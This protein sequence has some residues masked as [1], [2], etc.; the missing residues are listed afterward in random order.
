MTLK[1]IFPKVHI[2]RHHCQYATVC[3]RVRNYTQKKTAYSVRK[4][5]V[6]VWK[7]L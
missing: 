6:V 7:G 1:F 4:Y 2:D 3:G 5:P